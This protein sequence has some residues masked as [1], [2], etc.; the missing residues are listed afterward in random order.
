MNC[1]GF[2]VYCI[3]YRSALV[4]QADAG[5]DANCSTPL[6]PALPIWKTNH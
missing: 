2:C 1:A 6:D 4:F 3:I 5:N